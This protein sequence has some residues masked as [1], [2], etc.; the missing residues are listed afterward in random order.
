MYRILSSYADIFSFF[1]EYKEQS[2]FCSKAVECYK[3]LF[4]AHKSVK[5]TDCLPIKTLKYHIREI[6]SSTVGFLRP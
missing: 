3:G 2:S 6:S 1:V 4:Y 5:D